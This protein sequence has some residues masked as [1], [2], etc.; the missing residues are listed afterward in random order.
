MKHLLRIFVSALILLLISIPCFAINAEAW[1]EFSGHVG[2]DAF[3]SIVTES[4][5]QGYAHIV[6]RAIEGSS[7]NFTYPI[8][9][10]SVS[11]NQDSVNSPIDLGM[12]DQTDTAY[13]N[14]KLF[15][16]GQNSNFTEL[17]L[18][19]IDTSSYPTF[20]SPV[21]ITSISASKFFCR[22][23]IKMDESNNTHIAWNTG[24]YNGSRNAFENIQYRKRSSDGTL[25][26]TI[27]IASNSE[28]VG[29]IRNFDIC[30][31]N[32]S[33]IH[34]ALSAWEPGTLNYR[35]YYKIRRPNGSS[36]TMQQI[37]DGGA[38]VLVNNSISGKVY[39]FHGNN[40]YGYGINY[41]NITVSGGTPTLGP[42][43]SIDTSI[44]IP[45]VDVDKNGNMHVLYRKSVSGNY[46]T[47][48]R[49]ITPDE[50]VSVPHSF[51]NPCTNQ[52]YP[53]P[54]ITIDNK[55]NARAFWLWKDPAS[56]FTKEIR[57]AENTSINPARN[58]S[59][60][61]ADSSITL[62][63]DIPLM[64]VTAILDHYKVT[65]S[66]S[67][68]D[69]TQDIASGETSFIKTG[70]DNNTRYSCSIK[71]VY[72]YG[73]I[74]YESEE[75][76][77]FARPNDIPLTPENFII[78]AL[79]T[80]GNS[81]SFDW[82]KPDNVDLIGYIIYKGTDPGNLN[83]EI[84]IS[85]PNNTDYVDT[86]VD[87]AANSYFYAISAKD[88]EDLISPTSEVIST[89]DTNPP[90]IPEP[91]SPQ[92]NIWTN[93]SQEVTFAWTQS[94]DNRVTDSGLKH[95]LFDFDG[96]IYTT[97]ETS[98]ALPAAGLM[99]QDY[100]WKVCAE[101]NKGNI[102]DWSTERTIKFDRT[103]PILNI[104]DLPPSVLN[105]QDYYTITGDTSDSLGEIDQVQYRLDAG[106]PILITN[107]SGPFSF[108]ISSL[109][110]GEH[111][112]SIT[113]FDKAG[114]STETSYLFTV[115]SGG[116]K[117]VFSIDNKEINLES[118]PDEITINKNTK[119]NFTV[120]DGNGIENIVLTIEAESGSDIYNWDINSPSTP[121]ENEIIISDLEIGKY[122]IL[123]SSEDSTGLVTGFSI[124]AIVYDTLYI[125]GENIAYPNPFKPGL[126][127][128]PVTFKYE[129]SK[130]TQIKFI[131][132][133]EAG[134][135]V[136][137]KICPA[138]TSGGY[139]GENILEWDTL[140][141]FGDPA[142]IGPYYYFIITDG[143]IL[144]KGS[145]AAFK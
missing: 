13:A 14:N 93:A 104:T 58:L 80:I 110:D 117:I 11:L 137:Q 37:T 4:D 115:N 25:S 139:A 122:T 46:K 24:Y 55:G 79:D 47:T 36:S 130:E 41:R 63:W 145:I 78:T 3:S 40:N 70:L 9:M 48:Y 121:Y 34:I 60:I 61:T 73:G 131:L 129:L 17:Q 98:F 102:S 67:G 76:F 29:E 134:K 64:G 103:A 138:G 53:P 85:G 116:P 82:D 77:L 20:S 68:Y 128:N 83:E 126:E 12:F 105:F 33:N 123:F 113:A 140:D 86:N 74:T 26:S 57:Y 51:I 90:T 101:D 118:I 119:I 32:D 66:K 42:K 49:R 44:S 28:V 127:Q 143:K 95:Y 84:E 96:S 87:L 132:Y 23:L 72:N 30:V 27:T 100:V 142:P 89:E 75:E 56:P 19:E 59:A 52:V 62:N 35:Y 135:I 50:Q 111:L 92:D 45:S 133:N 136:F 6:Y 2:D 38:A 22:Y 5:E 69:F 16:I 144:G 120:T 124:T 21:N 43:I 8:K 125:I 71:A 94:F 54:A 10:A 106:S 108:T 65:I 81:V 15:V 114:N 31:D 112:L 7:P 97:T 109:T 88:M 1:E 18:L 99:E 91:V 107:T 39:L 141:M